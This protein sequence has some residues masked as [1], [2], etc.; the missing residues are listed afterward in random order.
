M[1]WERDAIIA[2]LGRKGFEVRNDTDHIVLTFGGLTRSIYTKLS[3]GTKFKTMMTISLV[4]YAG[5]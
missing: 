4:S 5:S 1:V 2:S 3:R